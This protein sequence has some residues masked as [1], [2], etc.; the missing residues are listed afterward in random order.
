MLNDLLGL[1]KSRRQNLHLV[2]SLGQGTSELL[3]F[4]LQLLLGEDGGSGCG[5][6]GDHASGGVDARYEGT[7]S[8]F[9]F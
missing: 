3:Q 8:I 6:E 7:H 1:F 4:C 5:V 9:T 2:G